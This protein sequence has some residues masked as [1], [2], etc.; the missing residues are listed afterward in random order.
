MVAAVNLKYSSRSQKKL[1]TESI[2]DKLFTS[3]VILD[4]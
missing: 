2:S 4:S 1:H 3:Q